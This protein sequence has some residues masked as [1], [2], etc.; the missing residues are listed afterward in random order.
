MRQAFTRFRP[1]STPISRSQGIFLGKK[2]KAALVID[3]I[4]RNKEQ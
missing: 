1:I 3:T 4:K 2:V